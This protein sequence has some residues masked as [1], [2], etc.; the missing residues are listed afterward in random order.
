[1]WT[2]I[3]LGALACLACIFNAFT[4]KN[5][6]SRIKRYLWWSGF[7][8]S[9]AL[10]FWGSYDSYKNEMQSK[11][12]FRISL[13]AKD[14]ISPV[15]SREAFVE[16]MALRD[17]LADRNDFESDLLRQHVEQSWQTVSDFYWKFRHNQ[18]AFDH[19]LKFHLQAQLRRLT[20][21]QVHW[22][23]RSESHS[24][25]KRIH[26]KYVVE[27]KLTYFV[28]DLVHLAI[29]DPD[30][31][32]ASSA[33]TALEN[34]TNMRFSSTPPYNEVQVWWQ[35]QGNQIGDYRHPFH[36]QA[37]A[38]EQFLLN[39]ENAKLRDEALAKMREVINGRKGFGTLLA[40]L[41]VSKLDNNDLN[42]AIGYYERLWDECDGFLWDKLTYL[43]VLSESAPIQ[44]Q[45]LLDELTDLFPQNELSYQIAQNRYFRK[46]LD[47]DRLSL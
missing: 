20:A 35:K 10:T 7:L 38:Y 19:E 27:R 3:I 2:C 37:E 41:A 8:I 13:L 16:L 28:E 24:L 18:E 11:L 22:Y 12:Q 32:V 45:R 46:A 5:D 30:L 42:A 47:N 6:N 36:E 29:H 34:I 9:L 43:S 39:F 25:Q 15:E 40:F 26:T 33:V 44:A 21:E 31:R 17:S 23:F 4:A 14:A 1:M